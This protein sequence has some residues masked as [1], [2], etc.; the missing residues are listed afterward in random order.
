MA[1][2]AMVL[3]AAGSGRRLFGPC[4]AGTGQSLGGRG[5]WSAR[6][7]GGHGGAPAGVGASG[8]RSAGAAARLEGVGAALFGSCWRLRGGGWV[9]G[10][11]ALE[12]RDAADVCVGGGPTR[13]FGAESGSRIRCVG[14]FGP[15]GTDRPGPGA[16]GS[17]SAWDFGHRG[18]AR[19]G[20]VPVAFSLPRRRLDRRKG[21]LFGLVSEGSR[22]R[23]AA[24]AP[25]GR[26][27][28]RGLST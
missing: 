7:S 15:C 6:R 1:G 26:R 9:R 24:G 10:I 16:W 19:A 5:A 2:R 14:L 12:A 3:H 25:R 4:R 27:R 20:V 21:G 13:P 23:W 28:A 17:R 8:V 22:G 11:G 18:F